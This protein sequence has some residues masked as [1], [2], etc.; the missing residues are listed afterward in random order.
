MRTIAITNM[1][2]YMNW[3]ESEAGILLFSLT[4]DAWS[5]TSLVHHR[6]NLELWL[7]G[8][9]L[10]YAYF[11]DFIIP[12]HLMSFQDS[13]VYMLVHKVHCDQRVRVG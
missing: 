6:D 7:L 4:C 5:K 11:S 8:L 1:Y 13:S 3:C 9:A 2:K 12:V 10:I